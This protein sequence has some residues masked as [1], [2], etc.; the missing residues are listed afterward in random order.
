M[1]VSLELKDNTKYVYDISI[2][3]EGTDF[4]FLSYGKV[5]IYYTYID[6]YNVIKISKIIVNG[7]PNGILKDKYDDCFDIR[8]YKYIHIL[9]KNSKKSK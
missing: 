9:H 4:D 2:I 3:E 8:P 6:T 5:E 7:V 1:R